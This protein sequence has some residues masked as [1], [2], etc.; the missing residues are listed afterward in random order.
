MWG[1]K[2]KCLASCYFYLYIEQ[3]RRSIIMD[4]I[5]DAPAAEKKPRPAES[6]IKAITEDED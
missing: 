5:N 3:Q 6:D 4:C 1:V 2:Q